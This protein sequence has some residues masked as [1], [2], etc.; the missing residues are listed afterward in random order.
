[1][2]LGEFTLAACRHQSAMLRPNGGMIRRSR[3]TGPFSRKSVAVD[4]MVCEDEHLI[5]CSA[6]R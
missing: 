4:R 5:P 1:M 2:V 3:T 6:S